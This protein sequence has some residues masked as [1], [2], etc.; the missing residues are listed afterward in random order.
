M[1]DALESAVLKALIKANLDVIHNRHV[2]EKSDVLE[3]SGY[4]GMVDLDCGLSGYV[5]SLQTDNALVRLVY[6]G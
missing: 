5:L 3:G 4:S 6:A 2:L 1:K